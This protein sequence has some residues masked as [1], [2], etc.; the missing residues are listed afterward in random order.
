[1]HVLC[2]RVR[3]SAH[4]RTEFLEFLREAIPVYERPGGIRVRLLQE[5]DDAEAFCEM[6][7]YDSTEL[8][9]LDQHRVENDPDMKR[10]IAR[11][12]EII[13]GPPVVDHYVEIPGGNLG[14]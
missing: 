6:I 8:F 3:V 9:E 4:R 12:R 2:L 13:G 11:W 1:M 7:E 14:E 5:A 10:L